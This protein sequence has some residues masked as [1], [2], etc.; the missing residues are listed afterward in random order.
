MNQSKL[1]K[2]VA[3]LIY[4]IFPI[5]GIF[6]T[7]S[8]ILLLIRQGQEIGSHSLWFQLLLFFEVWFYFVYSWIRGGQTLGMRAWKLGI[9]DHHTMGWS[10]A[11][12]RFLTGLLSTALLGLGL[13]AKLWRKDQQTWMDLACG[14]TTMD[15]SVNG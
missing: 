12:L 8:L 9:V 10:A 2:H 1:W 3:A 6:L 7:T 14:R 11:T 13:W 5:L 4:D 15:V